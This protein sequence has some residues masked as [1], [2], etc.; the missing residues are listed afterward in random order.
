MNTGTAPTYQMPFFPPYT[1]SDPPRIEW[2]VVALEEAKCVCH[3]QDY[4][5]KKHNM[6]SCCITRQSY[7][8]VKTR[9]ILSERLSSLSPVFGGFTHPLLGLLHATETTTGYSISY[10]ELSEIYGKHKDVL[11]NDPKPEGTTQQI[12]VN[13]KWA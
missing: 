5:N 12:F 13:I 7:C 6:L 11:I 10:K 2:A 8:R 1:Q 3:K 4:K 9:N